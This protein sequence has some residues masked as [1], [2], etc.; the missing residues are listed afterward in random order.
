VPHWAQNE[1]CPKLLE[2]TLRSESAP[3]ITTQSPR[4]IEAKGWAGVP[5]LSWQVR[6]WHQP[7]SNGSLVSS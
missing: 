4:L 1:R 7:Q 5:L 3:E 6:Q 2:R